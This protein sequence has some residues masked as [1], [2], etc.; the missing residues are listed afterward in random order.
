MHRLALFGD[1]HANHVALMAVLDAVDRAGLRD[2]VCTGDVVMRGAAPGDCID[3]LERRGWPVVMGNT[4]HKVA[5]R[6]PRDADHPK[7]QR[8]GSRSWT[9]AHISPRQRAFLCGLPDRVRLTVGGLRVVVTHAYPDDPRNA[10]D[11]ATPRR[12]LERR[13]R[14]AEADVMVTGHTH[15]QLVRSAGGCLFINPGSVGEVR[16]DDDLDPRWAWL[17]VTDGRPLVHLERIDRPLRTIRER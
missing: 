14:D 5:S 4:D 7:A 8:V 15:H 16:G 3:E 13:A 9:S 6:P 1:I 17:E 2:A 12:D 10:I 11:E